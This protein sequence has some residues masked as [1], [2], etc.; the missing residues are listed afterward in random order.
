MKKIILIILVLISS[1]LF[2]QEKITVQSGYITFN[3]NAMFDFKDM[4]IERMK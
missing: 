4:V 2:A 1:L 3:S